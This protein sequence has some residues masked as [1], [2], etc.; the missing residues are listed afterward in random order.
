M[1]FGAFAGVVTVVAAIGL[2]VDDRM[3][4]GAPIWAKPCKFAFSFGLYAVTW[5]WMLSLQRK[6]V[7]L[8]RVLGT[9]AAVACAIEVAA[10]F[11]QTIRG[12]RSHFN[13]S[14]PLDAAM[15]AIM[16]GSIMVLWIANLIGAILL[17]KERHADRP[18]MWALR[19][20]SL[21]T[22]IGMTLAFLMTWGTTDQRAN[23]PMAIIGSHSVGVPDG[24][25]GMAVTNW[26]ST[27]GDL[28]VGH[29]IGV[30]GLQ[31]VPLFAVLLGML[32]VGMPRLRDELVR[33]RLVWTFAGG[34]TGLMALV[35]WQALRKQP[36][37]Q[38]DLLTIGAF[39]V[40]VAG[41]IGAAAWVLRASARPAPA[42]V[43]EEVLV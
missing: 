28:R 14:T 11:I 31:M 32:M 6:H 21:V 26:S 22:L 42:A 19:L 9:W 37:L 35:T 1:L 17:M 43:H 24:G 18:A 40:L 13:V 29:F 39:S 8:G 25:P 23:R 34:Y 4:V 20:G 30:H 38:P 10:V 27:G 41:T 16:A 3:L 7:K 2:V 36:L 15:W 33:I 12:H 5:A